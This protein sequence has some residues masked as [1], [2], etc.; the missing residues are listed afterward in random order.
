MLHDTAGLRED[1]ANLPNDILPALG[2]RRCPA[3]AVSR[4]T[5]REP[6]PTER[7]D[8]SEAIYRGVCRA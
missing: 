3:D 6:M 7:Y 8:G 2:A 4:S 5:G 1:V